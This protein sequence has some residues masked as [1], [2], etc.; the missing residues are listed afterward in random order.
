[1]TIQVHN[2]VWY[3]S[4]NLEIRDQCNT[5]IVALDSS[6][7]IIDYPGQSPDEELID[8]AELITGKPVKYILLTHAHCD[9][10]TGFRTLK[11]KDITVVARKSALE[12]MKLE[13]YPVPGAP[14]EITGDADLELDGFDFRLEVP[15]SVTHSPWDMLIGLPKYELVFTGDLVVRPKYMFFHSSY[16][17]GWREMI[18]LLMDRRWRYLAMGHG[19]VQPLEWLEEVE[20]YLALLAEAKDIL[21]DKPAYLD[22][23]EVLIN[24]PALPPELVSVM[25]ELV[26][27]TDVKNAIRQVLQLDLRTREGF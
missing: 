19:A 26:S 5:G 11:R 2:D 8:E 16:L 12:N 14:I 6:A 4:A 13:G 25:A 1:M 10:V 21:A 27:I 7:A 23:R 18:A 15:P 17:Q 22:E 20:R 9:H 24:P 3:R